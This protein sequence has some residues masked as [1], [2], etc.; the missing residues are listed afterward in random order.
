ML[1]IG[2]IGAGAIG[3]VHL[4]GFQQNKDCK[5]IAVAS[6]TKE[7]VQE[8][9]EKFNIPKQFIGDN[10]KDLLREDIDAVSICTPNYLH[11]PMIL[12]AIKRDVHILCEKP[13]SISLRELDR[14][15]K[16]L[17]E[18]P[19][20]FY[21]AFNKRYNPLFSRIKEGIEEGL[22]GKILNSRYYLSHYGPYKS[23]RAKSK[24]KWFYDSQKAGG[25][26]LLDLGIHCIDLF[27]YLLG[28][29]E[30]IEGVSYDTFCID[31]EH[32]DTC[33]V[34]FRFQDGSLGIISVSWCN[35]PSEFIE[36]FGRK[37]TLKV[38]LF[39]N[40]FALSP[41]KL[42]RDKLGKSIMNFKKIKENTHSLLID[43][44]IKSIIEKKYFSYS[45]SFLNGKRAVE[46]VLN[47]YKLNSDNV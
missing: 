47:T 8:T 42:K 19:L 2:L 43:D 18:K 23:W 46:F 28:E 5:V 22:L 24:E 10:W 41:G 29:F 7:H 13:I 38:N 16:A 37:G 44:F 25:G 14:I 39:T 3:D 45:P 1:K 11:A 21:T 27:R 20:I 17:N 4:Q 26:V 34:N 40:E 36:I 33:N 31:M 35:Y 6:R 15:E 9:A 12:E 32:E 30:S